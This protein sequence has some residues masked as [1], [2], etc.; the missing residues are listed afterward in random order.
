MSRNNLVSSMCYV[1]I[2]KSLS[3]K[4]I[5]LPNLNFDDVIISCENQNFHLHLFVKSGALQNRKE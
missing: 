4:Y 5:P 1:R 2:P 3:K